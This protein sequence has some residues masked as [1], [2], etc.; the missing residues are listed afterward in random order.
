MRHVSPRTSVECTRPVS[1][2]RRVSGWSVQFS[3]CA[4]SVHRCLA[5][6]P[7]AQ[8][9]ARPPAAAWS[10]DGQLLRASLTSFGV[11]AVPDG[12]VYMGA[13]AD[14]VLMPLYFVN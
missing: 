5:P 4:A 1:G 3:G 12:T 2:R 8:R 10:P 14:W 6:R 9:R 7:T 11:W 13:E